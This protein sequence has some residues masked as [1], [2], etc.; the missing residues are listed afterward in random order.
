LNSFIKPVGQRRIQIHLQRDR[1]GDQNHVKIPVG[2]VVGLKREDE[3]QCRKQRRDGNRREARQ[4][5]F[6][7]PALAAPANL[8]RAQNASGSQRNHDK[9]QHG[10]QQNRKRN[11]K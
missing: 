11:G 6:L 9:D 7:K 3:D 2:D 5:F 10:I 8:Q 4:E 1:Y